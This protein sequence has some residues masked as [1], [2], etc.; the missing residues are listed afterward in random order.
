MPWSR[1]FRL[2]W[3]R[4]GSLAQGRFFCLQ[5]E[6]FAGAARQKLVHLGL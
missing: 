5:I 6:E 2:R 1:W 4:I 3:E